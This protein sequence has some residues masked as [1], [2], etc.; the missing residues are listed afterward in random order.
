MP[1]VPGPYRFYEELALRFAFFFGSLPPQVIDKR[2]RRVTV[3]D[4]AAQT[5]SNDGIHS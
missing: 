3:L 5:F 1:D 2:S 4:Q